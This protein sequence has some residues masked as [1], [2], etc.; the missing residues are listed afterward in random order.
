MLQ[1]GAAA[2]F[3]GCCTICI[4]MAHSLQACHPLCAKSRRRGSQKGKGRHTPPATSCTADGWPLQYCTQG[5][6]NGKELGREGSCPRLGLSQ[7]VP[8]KRLSHRLTQASRDTLPELDL[9]RLL[10]L[11]APQ[12]LLTLLSYICAEHSPQ[13]PLTDHIAQLYA[14]LVMQE[15]W[16]CADE[17]DKNE[18]IQDMQLKFHQLW[19]HGTLWLEHTLMQMRLMMRD[20]SAPDVNV[21]LYAWHAYL[22]HQHVGAASQ[23]RLSCRHGR[24]AEGRQV[25][26]VPCASVL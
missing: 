12:L 17:E 16:E 7:E 14:V 13:T 3:G 8:K 2:V 9:V 20:G 18:H 1:D 23:S 22:G 24:S 19:L 5:L 6:P 11:S 26:R 15:R 21:L 25:T 4:A 10:L